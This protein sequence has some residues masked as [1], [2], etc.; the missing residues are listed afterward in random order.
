MN[1]WDTY[2]L[3]EKKQYLVDHGT[4]MRQVEK[5]IYQWV[6]DDRISPKEMGELLIACYK[7][8]VY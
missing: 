3:A 5:I 8:L 1:R 4:D 7:K 6:K 2:T